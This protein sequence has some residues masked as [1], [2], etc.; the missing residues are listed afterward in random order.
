MRYLAKRKRP[1]R[2]HRYRV[3]AQQL[4]FHLSTE[5]TGL[6]A[7]ECVRSAKQSLLQAAEIL[8][9]TEACEQ[10]PSPGRRHGRAPTP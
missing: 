10:A 2:A 3:L 5:T 9:R 8:E 4:E 7:Y 6:E 1:E